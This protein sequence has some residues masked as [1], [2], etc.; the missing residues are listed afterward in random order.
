MNIRGRRE[1]GT[2]LRSLRPAVVK[3]PFSPPNDLCGPIAQ[4]EIRDLISPDV[5]IACTFYARCLINN[6]AS[7][8]ISVYVKMNDKLSLFNVRSRFNCQY[9]FFFWI[10]MIY[11]IV[12][13]RAL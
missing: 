11:V 6:A 4:M 2:D 10:E 12:S 3:R 9:L 5:F 7:K 13:R 1:R 8:C